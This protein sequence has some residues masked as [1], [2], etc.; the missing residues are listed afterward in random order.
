MGQ[1]EGELAPEAKLSVLAIPHPAS[2][3][4]RKS[5][6]HHRLP[7]ALVSC[8]DQQGWMLWARSVLSTESLL[9]ALLCKAVNL[10]LNDGT[11]WHLL[12]W[13]PDAGIW[14]ASLLMN[15]NWW[16]ISPCMIYLD[17]MTHI[18]E[19]N[20]SRSQQRTSTVSECS[21]ESEK[22][23]VCCT[24]STVTDLNE[25]TYLWLKTTLPMGDMSFTEKPLSLSETM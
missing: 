4:E 24:G 1:W 19:V 6:Q 3:K 16:N 9:Q 15:H 11:G 21:F 5:T 18:L 10:L 25:H 14:Y 8:C 13:A 17:A 22:T 12:G 7:S 23:A 20:S 2:S